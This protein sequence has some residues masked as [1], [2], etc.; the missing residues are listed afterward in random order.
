MLENNGVDCVG[1]LIDL[2]NCFVK[3]CLG[4]LDLFERYFRID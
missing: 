3:Y 4:K 2:R 1:L